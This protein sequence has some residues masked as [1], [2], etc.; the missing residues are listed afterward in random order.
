MSKIE[1]HSNRTPAAR[2]R[3]DGRGLLHADQAPSPDDPEDT[4]PIG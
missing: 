1:H 2:R 3:R 4:F